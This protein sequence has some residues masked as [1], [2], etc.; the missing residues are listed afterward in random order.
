MKTMAS[1]KIQKHLRGYMAKKLVSQMKAERQQV[2]K[3]L[4]L[5]Q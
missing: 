4:L 1:V 5:V 3:D 2:E